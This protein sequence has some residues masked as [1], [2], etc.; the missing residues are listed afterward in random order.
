MGSIVG[1]RLAF[2]TMVFISSLWLN[3]S[4]IFDYLLKGSW[5]R[6]GKIPPTAEVSGSNS[7]Q[8]MGKLVFFTDGHQFTV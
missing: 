3:L 2:F 1:N 5:W 6:S 8:Y 4:F 7:G